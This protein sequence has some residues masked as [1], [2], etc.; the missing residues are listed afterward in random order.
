VRRER[1]Q[2][3]VEL[4][5]CAAVLVLAAVTALAVLSAVRARIAAERIADQAAVLLAERRP[6]PATL[7]DGAEIRRAGNRVVVT[8]ALPMAVP[9]MPASESAAAVLPR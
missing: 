8:V 3:S 9:G 2:A 5:A 6:L 7:R 4:V 1:G